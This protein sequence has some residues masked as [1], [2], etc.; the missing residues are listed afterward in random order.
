VNMSFMLTEPQVSDRSKDVTRRLGWRRLRTGDRL[1]PVRKCQGLRRGE[2]VQRIGTATL[3]V[4]E[5]RREPL[6]RLLDDPIYGRYE[7]D[8]EGFPT[9]TVQW[10][11]DM[12]CK[13]NKCTP[14]TEV[15]RIA[16]RY[17]G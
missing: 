14:D 4:L 15:T 1:R 9:E 10:F 3:V 8:R 13:A 2:Q 17:E 12:F 5:T 6:R 11:V 16:F 7:V